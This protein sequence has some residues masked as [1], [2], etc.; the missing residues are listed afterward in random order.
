MSEWTFASIEQHKYIYIYFFNN[1][2]VFTVTFDQL[3]TSLPKKS[4]KKKEIDPKLLNAS[5]TS[6]FDMVKT[7]FFIIL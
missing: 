5:F 1:V 7:L 4:K 3:N 2:T 6:N